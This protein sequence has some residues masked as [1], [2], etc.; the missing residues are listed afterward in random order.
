LQRTRIALALL[1]VGAAGMAAAF[2]IPAVGS[3]SSPARAGAV[4]IV[5]TGSD[6]G[7]RVSRT[8]AP[9]GTVVFKIAN[10]GR[11]T[12]VFVVAGKRTTVRAHRSATAKITFRAA[13]SYTWTWTGGKSITGKIRITGSTTTTV[14]TTTTTTTATVPGPATTITV[15]MF[16]YRFALSQ[17]TV[18]S[19]TVTFVI[20]NKGAE[21]HNF[22]LAGV[23]AGKL[24]TPG[25]S[26]TWTVGLV[27]KAYQYVCDVPF[28]I[29]RGMLG[30]LT[31]TSS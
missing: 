23:K 10:K 29:D 7:V 2:A 28:H 9:R 26:E 18:P 5:V 21:V 27:P 14:T 15:D 11:R 24:L 13:G 16:E 12:H 17:T 25:Q 20:T 19:G 1:A 3:A 6:T 4:T 31:V 30:A 8:S 22:D